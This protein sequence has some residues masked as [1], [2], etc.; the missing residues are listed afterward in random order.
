MRGSWYFD[1]VRSSDTLEI[2]TALEKGQ[3]INNFILEIKIYFST[4]LLHFLGLPKLKNHGIPHLTKLPTG[5]TG[6]PRVH[7][8]DQHR[9]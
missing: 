1:S 6:V 4:L 3:S 2:I 8:T 9:F 7:I 5:H